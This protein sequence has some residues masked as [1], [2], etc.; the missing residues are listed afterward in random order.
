MTGI[1]RGANGKFRLLPPTPEVGWI[2]YAWLISLPILYIEAGAQGWRPVEW[3]FTIAGSLLFLVTYFRGYWLRDRELLP[4]IAL[5]SALGIA[6]SFA[7]TGAAIF[8]I[9][10]AAWGGR[11]DRPRDVW[12]IVGGIT[13]LALLTAWATNAPSYF[14]INCLFAPFVAAVNAHFARVDRINA[15]LK[16]AQREVVHLAAI[17][18][19]ERIARD[20][21]DVLGH[22]LS[23][24]TLKAELASKLADIDP[25]RAAKEI[26]DVEAVSRVALAEMREAVRGYRTTLAEELLAAR[27]LLAA[28]NIGLEVSRE[29]GFIDPG[30]DAVLGMAVRE[31]VTNVV[32]HSGATV[33]KITVGLG[34][35][36]RLEVRDD[37][38]GSLAVDGSGLRGVRRRVEDARGALQKTTERGT[39]V[40]VE[41]PVRRI[42]NSREAALSMAV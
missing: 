6:F 38:R 39:V 9:Y 42:S 11:L 27:Q 30:L 2:P 5:H 12:S 25:T 36:I 10:A 8:F 7:N 4:T 21:H 41:L 23:L 37:G 20:L 24:I 16:S 29:P 18:E 35:Q 26:R 1:M 14:W 22:S 28:A 13:G 34:D 19:R 32:R 3:V 31:L 33:C 15:S 17:A 40:V